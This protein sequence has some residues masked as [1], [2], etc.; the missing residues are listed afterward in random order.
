MLHTRTV[1][2]RNGLTEVDVACRHNLGHGQPAEYTEAAV[3]S[4]NCA[5]PTPDELFECAR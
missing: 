3:S 4:P 5:A 2:S 1:L